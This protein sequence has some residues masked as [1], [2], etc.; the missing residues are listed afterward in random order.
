MAQLVEHILGKDEVP[1]SNL[2]SSS[3]QKT[4]P[5]GCVFC[6]NRYLRFELGFDDIHAYGVILL[7]HILQPPLFIPPKQNNNHYGV[8]K[9]RKD[10]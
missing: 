10:D 7:K 8:C 1:S 5:K 4:H 3:K 9:M 2:G 6:L